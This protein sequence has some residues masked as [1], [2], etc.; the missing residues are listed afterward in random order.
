MSKIRAYPMVILLLPLVAAILLY[1]HFYPA[2][3]KQAVERDYAFVITSEAKSTPKFERFETQLIA[4]RDSI[5][6][7]GG[8][9]KGEWKAAQGQVYLYL[10]RDSANILPGY[11]DT[12]VAH[13]TINYDRR[14]GRA[15]AA[16]YSL[17]PSG[18]SYQPTL[19]ERLYRRLEST[20]LSGD[21]LAIV[22][23]LTLGYK[24]DLD[25]EVRHR[26]QSSGAAHV[27]AVSGLHTGILYVLILWL[28]TMGGRFKPRYENRWGRCGISLLIIGVMWCYAWITG[29]TPSVVRAVL[30][31]TIVEIGRMTYRNSLSIN[32][33]AA[34]AVL[35]LLIRPTDLWSVS[36]QLSF[37]ATFAIVIMASRLEPFPH[38]QEWKSRALNWILGTII[39]SIAAQLGTL[40]IT[41]YNFGQVST[42]FL[43]TNLI[44]LPLATVLVPFGLMSM[45]FGG[46]WLGVLTGKITWRLAWMMNESV[47]W[48]ERLPGSTVSAHINGL[49]IG[50]YYGLF[51]LFYVFMIKK[52]L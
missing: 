49:M 15:F 50:L 44:V 28:L 18:I 45:L 48:I 13:T 39:V 38:R 31:V 17:Q 24:E 40:P 5:N 20:G 23:A 32:T 9:A 3:T 11:H 1:D 33:I 29:M 4:Q 27:L 37:S 36:F 6:G 47:G 30:M 21:E 19:Q 14:T 10:L 2:E 51:L 43:L 46:S 26:F 34:A 35:I 16:R 42:Y 25:P 8:K 41:M 22:G 12:I 7:E 52:R